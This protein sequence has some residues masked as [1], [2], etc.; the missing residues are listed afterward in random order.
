MTNSLLYGTSL[1][2]DKIEQLKQQT[3]IAITSTHLVFTIAKLVAI[4]N[5]HLYTFNTL[6]GELNFC[7]AVAATKKNSQPVEKKD[8]LQSL[9]KYQFWP[10]SF[11]FSLYLNRLTSAF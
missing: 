9:Q 6:C 11:I 7:N 8:F 10:A 4:M 2:Y 3:S 1:L 5:K